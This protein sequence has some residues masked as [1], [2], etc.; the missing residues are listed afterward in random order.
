MMRKQNAWSALPYRQRQQLKQMLL[1]RD[2]LVCCLCGLRISST[3]AATV[4]HRTK[5]SHGGA[6][7]DLANLGLAHATCNYSNR[8]GS[9]AVVVDDAA[10]FCSDNGPDIPR[11]VLFPPPELQKNGR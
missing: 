11:P 1:A 6:L 2:G 5:R 7:T 3:R 8:Y 4:E 9:D 10:F